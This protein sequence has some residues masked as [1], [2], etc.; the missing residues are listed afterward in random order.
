M[1]E[2]TVP[3]H[4]N[5]LAMD[6]F[7]HPRN[8]GEIPGA[9]GCGNAESSVCKDL[10]RVWIQVQ[11]GR[12]KAMGFKAHG[13]SAAIASGSMMTEMAKGLTVQE[14]LRLTPEDLS[15]ALGGIEGR[16]MHG[17]ALAIEGLRNA[18]GAL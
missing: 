17:P 15:R 11:D 13:C 12:I 2:E 7:R 9:H 8:V 10:M 3:F 14:A 4:L 16:R 18:I 6:H 1:A 5:D